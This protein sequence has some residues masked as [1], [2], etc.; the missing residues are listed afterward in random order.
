VEISPVTERKYKTLSWHKEGLCAVVD[1]RE[2][3]A[4]AEA[5]AQCSADLSELCESIAWDEEVRVVV[6]SFDGNIGNLARQTSAGETR[7]MSLAGPVAGLKLPVIAAV[8]GD[9]LGRGLELALACDIRIGTET[10]VFGMTQI[11]EGTIPADGGT[12][13]LPRLVGRSL[14]MRMIL[15]GEMIDAKEALRIGLVHRL[16]A[17]ESLISSA[18]DMAREMATKS[19]LSLSY[20]KE[21]L[22]SSMDLT[23]DQGVDKEMDLYLLLHSTSDR[24]EGIAAFRDK[25]KPQ[26][27]G[28]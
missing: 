8:R 15:T 23:L 27:K 5:L 28:N 24:I 3:T 11:C 14:A 21:A 25:R 22:Y 6:L 20:V 13:R 19:P 2:S 18:M 17:S 10:A 9:A 1:L 26:F 4:E 12:Q 16:A 7:S